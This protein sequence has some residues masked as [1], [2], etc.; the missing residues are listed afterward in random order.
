M[1]VVVVGVV[2]VAG[3]FVFDDEGTTV[4]LMVWGWIE[5]LEVGVVLGVVEVWGETVVGV[6]ALGAFVELDDEVGPEN[7]GIQSTTAG[8]TVAGC[9]VLGWTVLGCVVSCVVGCVVDAGTVDGCTDWGCT[10]LAFVV[11]TEVPGVNTG[12]TLIGW[13]LVFVVVVE[14][15]IWLVLT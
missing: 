13:V 10:V 14:E 12:C 5:L 15:A 6:I 9:E 3:V 1:L 11:F 7:A 2:V 4:G 8:W